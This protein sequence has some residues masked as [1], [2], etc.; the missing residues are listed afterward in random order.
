MAGV[1]ISIISRYDIIVILHLLCQNGQ[2][3]VASS[4]LANRFSILKCQIKVDSF[5]FSG[6][7]SCSGAV[8]W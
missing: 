3:H 7:Y 4:E 2:I 1:V 8:Y 6:D 5:L